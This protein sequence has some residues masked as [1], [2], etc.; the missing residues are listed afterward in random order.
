MIYFFCGDDLLEK[1]GLDKIGL[2]FGTRYCFS[3]RFYNRVETVITDLD[4]VHVYLE[5]IQ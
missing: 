2:A 5:E 1:A 4:T 3:A